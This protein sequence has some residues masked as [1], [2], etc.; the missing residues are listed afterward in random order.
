M[1][2]SLNEGSR[3]PSGAKVTPRTAVPLSP[4]RNAPEH[5]DRYAVDTLRRSGDGTALEGTSDQHMLT[6]SFSR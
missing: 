6:A 5:I 3:A 2:I 1:K 4:E